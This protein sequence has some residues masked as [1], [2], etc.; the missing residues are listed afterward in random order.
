MNIF[1]DK[2]LALTNDQIDWILRAYTQRRTTPLGGVLTKMTSDYN[3]LEGDFSSH[4]VKFY[5]QYTASI[6][7]SPHFDL[8]RSL[9]HGVQH[10][11]GRA[12]TSVPSVRTVPSLSTDPIKDREELVAN[13]KNMAVVT[14]TGVSMQLAGSG[15]KVLTWASLLIEL[16]S[17]IVGLCGDRLLKQL[18]NYRLLTDPSPTDPTESYFIQ[19]GQALKQLMELYSVEHGVPVDYTRYIYQAFSQVTA[20]D[21]SKSRSAASLAEAIRALNIPVA[22]TNYDML[23]EECLGRFEVNLLTDERHVSAADTKHFVYHLHGLWYSAQGLVL[24]DSSYRDHAET[25]KASVRKL[26]Q[27]SIK[28]LLFV[29]TKAG[30]FDQHFRTFLHGTRKRHFLLVRGD[31]E[32]GEICAEL[33]R[34][35]IPSSRLCVLSYGNDYG[36]LAKYLW[37]LAADAGYQRTVFESFT[38]EVQGSSGTIAVERASRRILEGAAVGVGA[39][40]GAGAG[41]GAAGV[42][43]DDPTFD[44][45]QHNF[46][47]VPTEGNV[48]WER[49]TVE[50]ASQ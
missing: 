42:L 10:L 29:G 45:D 20:S 38:R 9:Y 1:L 44:P 21:V 33:S 46:Q 8:F 32:V 25:F 12:Y 11:A 18:G 48:K 17:S 47:D 2:M 5:R 6:E 39:S 34:L 49:I 35:K 19:K 41:A 4:A 23:L 16:S 36:D 31:K 22:T 27:G 7:N 3:Q 37:R 14:G 28:Q 26:V 40:V 13:L 30:I 43:H 50:Y 15:K 24:V